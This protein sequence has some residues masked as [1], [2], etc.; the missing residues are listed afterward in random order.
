MKRRMFLRGVV[1][2]GA[3]GGSGVAEIE[4]ALAATASPMGPALAE[5]SGPHGGIPP[6]GVVKQPDIKPALL[7]GMDLYRADVKALAAEK[8]APTFDNTIA[9]F[10]DAGRPYGRASTFFNIYTST[11]N[12][13]A[14]QAVEKE[15]TP[16]LAALDDEV[17][18]N[19]PLFKRIQVVYDARDKASLNSEQQRLAEVYYERFARRGGRGG[20]SAR[21]EGQMAPHQYALVGRA[22]PHV[23]HA[24]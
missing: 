24:S 13:K 15:M 20:R 21:Q 14:M 6:F 12:D 8:T 3:L 2:T 7:K 4:R 19:E 23:L 5:W 16:L 22:V 11:M 9:K 10:E 1:V 17:T 18:Q